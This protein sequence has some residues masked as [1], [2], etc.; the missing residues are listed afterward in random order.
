[1]RIEAKLA[2]RIGAGFIALVALYLALRFGPLWYFNADSRMPG[3]FYVSRVAAERMI[4]GQNIYVPGDPSPFKYSPTFA[5]LFRY[6]V[7]LLEENFSP[8][9]WMVASA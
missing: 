3:D 2:H 9:F 7:F 1:M 5:Y 4:A 8:A 6:T